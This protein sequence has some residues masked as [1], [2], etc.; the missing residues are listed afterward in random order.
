MNNLFLRMAKI[1]PMSLWLLPEND[2]E[3]A[4][5]SGSWTTSISLSVLLDRQRSM[6]TRGN[7]VVC[8]VM[9]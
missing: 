5:E 6:M 2:D 3:D 9:R 4:G 8:W 7:T 1:F